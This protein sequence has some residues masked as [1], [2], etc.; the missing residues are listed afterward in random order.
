MKDKS[1]MPEP[2]ERESYGGIQRGGHWGAVLTEVGR[3]D[4]NVGLVTVWVK[5]SGGRFE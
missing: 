4:E 1:Y 5:S 3:G 2:G